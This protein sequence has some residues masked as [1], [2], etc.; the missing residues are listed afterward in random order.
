MPVD[1]TFAVSGADW[2]VTVP[3]ADLAPVGGQG[4]FGQALASQIGKLEGLQ[5]EAAGAA[6]DLATGR[7]TD[8]EAAVMA[9]ERARLAMQLAAQMRTKG[10]EALQD[11]FHT[12]I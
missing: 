2:S 7:S 10:V 12:Q 8:P 3:E 11:I 9:V 4:G 1:P 5:Q 6:R